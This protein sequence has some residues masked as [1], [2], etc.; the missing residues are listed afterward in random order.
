MLTVPARE[1]GVVRP[2]LSFGTF[3]SR[4]RRPVC[5]GLEDLKSL[6]IISRGLETERFVPSCKALA[7]EH[8]AIIAEYLPTAHVHGHGSLTLAL[9]RWLAQHCFEGHWLW[10]EYLTQQACVRW[11]TDWREISRDLLG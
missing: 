11:Q 7:A 9:Q 6:L 5:L 4:G 1:R 3:V 8:D 2:E 10:E